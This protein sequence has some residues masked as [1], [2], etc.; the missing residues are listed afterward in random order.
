MNMRDVVGLCLPY[1][2]AN[3]Q[4]ET[5]FDPASGTWTATNDLNTA[6][7]LHT[8]T[9]LPNGKVLVAAGQDNSASVSAELYDVGLGFDTAWQ[10]QITTSPAT[11]YVGTKLVLG[12]LQFQGVSQ[13]SNGTTQDSST[14]YPLA[15]LRNLDSG[16]VTF[17]LVD[18]TA[19]W[20]DTAFTSK[21]M[22]G[23]PSGPALVT[24]FTNGIPSDSK[25]LVVSAKLGYTH[26]WPISW[27]IM[28]TFNFSMLCR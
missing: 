14:N 28:G 15:Q 18:P 25:Y 20:S 3:S 21:P 19:G 10:P 27:T 11:L 24:V 1:G 23:F 7:Y 13:A 5:E 26:H 17:L 9:F 22:T 8:A 4:Y 12:G 6:R 2:R 16:Q